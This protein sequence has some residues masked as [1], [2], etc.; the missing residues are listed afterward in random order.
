MIS[1]PFLIDN[2]MN[3]EYFN[4][5]N[6]Y[7]ATFDGSADDADAIGDAKEEAVAAIIEFVKSSDLY[8]VILYLRVHISVAKSRICLGV[9]TQFAPCWMDIIKMNKGLR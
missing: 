9:T 8:Q 4:F 1:C 7:L 6:K 3:K 2:S 5:L